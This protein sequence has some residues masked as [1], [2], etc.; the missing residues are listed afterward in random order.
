[1][2]KSLKGKRREWFKDHLFELVKIGY[3]E[4]KW[5]KVTYFNRITI[6]NN[7]VVTLLPLY[8]NGY[9]EGRGKYTH[10]NDI[11]RR[12]CEEIG[13]VKDIQFLEFFVKEKYFWYELL[14][15]YQECLEKSNAYWKEYC[16]N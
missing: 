1:M 16:N 14:E 8:P 3:I 10:D 4:I 11:I 12:Y 5:H 7:G 9:H 13:M 15:M 2:S 6:D